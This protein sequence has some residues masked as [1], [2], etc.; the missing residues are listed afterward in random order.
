MMDSNLST[1]MAALDRVFRGLLPGDNLVWQVDA[2][3][4]FAP[5]VGP[6]CRGAR[7]AGGAGGGV[8]GGGAPP[9]GPGGWTPARFWPGSAARTAGPPGAPGGRW[10]TSALRA[11]RR[12]S[13]TRTAQRFANFAIRRGLTDL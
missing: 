12:W 5:F 2:I 11:I 8:G 6:Y 10:S 13:R 7:G 3:E 1:G 9:R 4:D